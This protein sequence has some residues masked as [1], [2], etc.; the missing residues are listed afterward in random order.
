MIL[1]IQNGFVTPSIQMYLDEPYEIFKSYETDVANICLDNYSI[2][3]ILGGHQSITKINLYPYLKNVVK[4]IIKCIY[5]NKN[6][7]GICLG[8][9]LIAYAIGCEIK[10]T[11]KLNVGYD[12]EILNFKNVF[13]CHYDYIITNNRLN[14]LEMF[15]SMV[16]LFSYKNNIIGIQCHPDISPETAKNYCRTKICAEYTKNNTDLINKQNKEIIN[17]LFQMFR[18]N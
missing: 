7:L 10:S 16:Y 3:I 9:Q 4:L 18:N 5:K 2:I 8:C 13:R 15:E 1:I 6:L 14:I 12:C 17:L 11:G